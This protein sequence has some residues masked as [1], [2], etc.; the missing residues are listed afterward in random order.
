MIDSAVD[1][2]QAVS[3]DR[4]TPKQICAE[5]L[6]TIDRTDSAID[7]WAWHDPDAAL[8]QA[9]VSEG[10][11]GDVKAETTAL[12]AN[13]EVED[14]EVVQNLSC[15]TGAENVF[16]GSRGKIVQSSLKQFFHSTVKVTNERGRIKKEPEAELD[17]AATDES[18]NT[19]QKADGVG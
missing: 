10:E 17:T 3:E 9:V 13:A 8:A 12:G 7:A 11:F 15:N 6:A 14:K 5:H 2:A 4:L 16:K 19:S 1:L 18:N